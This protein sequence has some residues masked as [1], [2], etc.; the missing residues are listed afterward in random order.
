[1]NSRN[2]LDRRTLL[3]SIGA[4]A[5]AALPAAVQANDRIS[6]GFIGMGS[7]GTENLKAAMAIPAIQVTALCDVYQPNLEQAGA[8]ARRGGHEPKE[9]HDFREILSNRSIDAVCISTP[10]HWHAYMAVEAC[11][12]GKDI[13][14]EKPA[15]V[16]IAEGEKMV[17]AARKYSRIVQAGTWQRSARHFQRAREIVQAGV[18]GKVS[19]CRTWIYQNMPKEG[20][21]S[22]VDAK[23]PAGLD[24]NLW[25]GPAQ[26]RPFNPNRFGVYPNR[27]AYFRYF[28]DYAGGHLT[29]SGVHMLDALQMIFDEAMPGGVTAMG[30]KYWVTDNSE[31]PD[32]MQASFEYPGFLGCWEHRCGN[33]ANFIS[34]QMGLQIHGDQAT[35]YVDRSGLSL[36]PEKGSSVQPESLQ[37]E[38]PPHPQ[39]WVN[40][41][42]CVKS[43]KRPNSEIETCVRSSATCILG[44]MAYQHKARID[45]DD[46]RKTILQ[47]NLRPFLDRRYRAPWKLEV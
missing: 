35:L 23:P 6:L 28:W 36:T 21:G 41:I 19:F 11:K 46:S 39:H 15:C 2:C 22:P 4:A 3:K 17:Q 42:E 25:L 18:L 44:N 8:A 29:D 14:V 45:W 34:R 27:Y 9:L 31:T 5:S 20:I 26:D 7:M 33:V 10:D 12:A 40:F 1:M 37:R 38:T 32:T 24:W 47:E 43:R 16:A 13:Y 30:G